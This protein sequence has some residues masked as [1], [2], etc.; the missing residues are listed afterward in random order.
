M[1]IFT[2]CRGVPPKLT[3]TTVRAFMPDKNFSA[4]AAMEDLIDN[5]YSLAINTGTIPTAD[6]PVAG[7]RVFDGARYFRD[8]SVSTDSSRLLGECTWQAWVYISNTQV[9]STSYF[10]SYSETGESIATNGLLA[11]GVVTN[12]T[13]EVT[14]LRAFWEYDDGTPPEGD[15]VICESDQK[16]P[17]DQW[18]HVACVRANDPDNAGKCTLKFYVNGA[19]TR[20]SSGALEIF[21][22]KDFPEGGTS[23][24]WVIGGWYGE[25]DHYFTGRV[26]PVV[27]HSAAA[28]DADIQEDYRRGLGWATNNR[29][30][31]RVLVE[32]NFGNMQDLSAVPSPDGGTVDML[33]GV[34]LDDS[35][36]KRV[37][38]A[39]V[40]IFRDH[41]RVNL[42]P[43]MSE[44][45]LNRASAGNTLASRTYPTR[46]ETSYV[47]PTETSP[48][49][50]LN[51]GR[52]VW[53]QMSRMPYGLS[54]DEVASLS[55]T[56][57]DWY[58][59]VVGYVDVVDFGKDVVSISI[60]D[61]GGLLA[62]AFI[63]SDIP[64]ST[65]RRILDNTPLGT[66]M[67]QV[68]TENW[69][70]PF[71]LTVAPVVYEPVGA[72]WLLSTGT[73]ERDLVLSAINKL[74]GQIAWMVRYKWNKNFNASGGQQF[75]LTLHEP[76]RDKV[77]S[78]SFISTDDYLNIS[79]LSLDISG[80]RNVVKVAYH[81]P[82]FTD[83]LPYTTSNV[84]VRP[85][86]LVNVQNAI[87]ASDAAS[88][89][90]YGRRYMELQEAPINLIDSGVEA[91]RMAN[92]I[93]ND[94][95][96]PLAHSSLNGKDLVEIELNDMLSIE[97][98][99]QS[100][101]SDQNYAV[102]TLNMDMKDGF[103]NVSLGLRGTPSS[104]SRRHISMQRTSNSGA[105]APF[106]AVDGGRATISAIQQHIRP[107]A[108]LAAFGGQDPSLANQF[109]EMWR[110][111]VND[112]L[113]EP[114]GW[115]TSGGTWGSAGDIYVKA[116]GSG[117]VAGQ[118]GS[119]LMDITSI[120]G[121]LKSDFFAIRAGVP[122]VI[123]VRAAVTNAGVQM[124]G[125]ISF[126]DNKKDATL[127]DSEAL[128]TTSFSA[129]DVILEKQFYVTAPSGVSYAKI[130]MFADAFVAANHLYLDMV[131]LTEAEPFTR[132]SISSSYAIPINKTHN[133][134]TVIELDQVDPPTVG[135]N[136]NTGTYTYTCPEAGLYSVNGSIC[137]ELAVST[138]NP[139]LDTD[140]AKG[141]YGVYSAIIVGSVLGPTGS[142]GLP[143]LR[144]E[145]GGTYYYRSTSAVSTKVEL[146]KGDTLKLGFF[147]AFYHNDGVAEPDFVND[148]TFLE[149]TLLNGEKR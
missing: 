126:Y 76:D 43:L 137:L 134:L 16:P 86:T 66:A 105:M 68:V 64:D 6:S 99:N 89:A 71:G 38:T 106:S 93:L 142:I 79:K 18:S 131:R 101:D 23:C 123:K 114:I 60:R 42:S 109:F 4:S 17:T 90:K 36:D 22:N 128:A 85:S 140:A 81:G 118:T 107:L 65:E 96:E 113:S 88:E 92:G 41:G 30:H 67:Q 98:N 54:P 55:A 78:D 115:T 14:G 143:A 132:A 58:N 49:T 7:G 63:E 45:Y 28:T 40:N 146:A 39:T 32:D 11:L 135:N 56:G 110:G 9:K 116:I 72:N 27:I 119:F 34:R 33:Q 44:S 3:S 51:I 125:E 100:F 57:S 124:G 104:G 136:F 73:I 83:T 48:T 21:T 2:N 94:L 144:M 102:S 80:V 69:K 29:V 62:D 59:L 147:G 50:F 47:S 70:S 139:S 35:I 133:D 95:R 84:V 24:R 10:L 120:S 82:A 25:V 87:T 31:M 149:V 15:N 141:L 26:G 127:I 97:A 20:T 74:A 75:R 37:T 52:A 117:A 129:N 130:E 112:Q 13:N 8:T 148:A 19:Q 111:G 77:I 12:A 138:S 91:N 53:V 121:K 108:S 103:V 122:Y 145:S 1:R 46:N 61:E 5:T